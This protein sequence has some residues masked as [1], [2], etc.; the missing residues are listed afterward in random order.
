MRSRAWSGAMPDSSTAPS[1]RPAIFLDRDGVIIE[2]RDDY[3]LRWEQVA[4][5]P[6]ALQALARARLAPHA[7]VII[8]NQSAIGRGLLERSTADEINSRLVSAIHASGG[9]ADG[10]YMCPHAPGAGCD[11]RKPRPGLLLQAARELSLDLRRSVLVGDALSDIEAGDA[12][13]IGQSILVQT[14]RGVPQLS[15]AGA[16]GASGFTVC[17]DL[18]E[19]LDAILGRK[20]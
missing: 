2:N 12:A 13:G 19:A 18:A 6:G 15:L 8:T 14:G 9:R 5:L 3:C 7:F 11:C 4:F 10:V 17:A 20:A 1:V 16:A